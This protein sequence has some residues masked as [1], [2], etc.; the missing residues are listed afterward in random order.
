VPIDVFLAKFGGA[1]FTFKYALGGQQRTVITYLSE[2]RIK[3][4]LLAGG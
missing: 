2:S 1:L 4:R 3:R